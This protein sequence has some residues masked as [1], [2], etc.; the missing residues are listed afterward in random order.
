MP[1]HP[2]WY[3]RVCKRNTTANKIGFLVGPSE[4]DRRA[5]FTWSKEGSPDI[6]HR[7]FPVD[8][9]NVDHIYLRADGDPDGAE[10]RV[11][12]CYDDHVVRH[13]DFNH[14]EDHE[15]DKNDTDKCEC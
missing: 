8:L 13:M 2:G 9:L 3:V 11:C 14:G 4:D 7:D 15:Q 1:N 12:I 10:C 5:W 6:F